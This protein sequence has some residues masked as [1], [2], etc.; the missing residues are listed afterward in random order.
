MRQ[1]DTLAEQ[2]QP[3][4]DSYQTAN[5]MLCEYAETGGW[6]RALYYARTGQ[7][8][9]PRDTGRQIKRWA[10]SSVAHLPAG[11][12]VSYKVLRTDESGKLAVMGMTITAGEA[13]AFNLPGVYT[14]PRYT[15]EPTK[16][17]VVSPDGQTT[18]LSPAYLTT[19]DEAKKLAAEIG[20]TAP[21]E[22]KPTGAFSDY[23]PPEEPRRAWVTIWKGAELQCSIYVAMKYANGIG[24]PGH[25]NLD[26]PAPAWV[27]EVN[28]TGAMDTRP[29]VLIPVRA[30]KANEEIRCTPFGCLV[31]RTDRGAGTSTGQAAGGLTA[32]QDA[33]LKRI[34]ADVSNI[35]TTVLTLSPA[36]FQQP[37]EPAIA[38]PAAGA[39]PNAGAA[40]ALSPAVEQ[41]IAESTQAATDAE[42]TSGA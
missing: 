32:G 8:A 17:L 33:L 3:T 25:W 1:P 23:F 7:Q 16:A 35:L 36:D 11:Q 10:D 20:S 15:I 22:N 4:A 28:K 26:G 13:A 42:Q 5:L 40:A 19:E 12:L 38:P 6:T 14:Y 2:P 24:A 29:E 21:T 34:G 18:P 30:L 41:A 27:S 9:P 37:A 39:D 31:F